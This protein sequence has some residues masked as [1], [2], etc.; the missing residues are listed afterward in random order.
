MKK[1]IFAF[2]FFALSYAQAQMTVT[3]L[4]GTPIVN[5]QIISF[6]S[7]IYNQ[8]SLG[9]K[10]NNT[11]S[12]TIYTRIR[13]ESITNT[14][15]IGM[16]LCVGPSCISDVVAGHSYPSNAVAIPANGTNGNSDHFY[17]SNPGN[18]VNYPMDY[19][20]KFYQVDTSTGNEIGNSITFTYRYSPNLVKESFDESLSNMGITLKSSLIQNQIDI[21]ALKETNVKI[22]D[23]NGKLIKS[24]N[25]ISGNNTI[26][27]S[28]L[29]TGVYILNCSNE[30]GKRGSIKIVKN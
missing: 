23:L 18:G 9:F 11:S 5:G 25:I 15:G 10:I 13:C 12:S 20:F 4:D 29:L 14:D 21:Q 1:I 30:E 22:Y 19:V 26:D 16:E 3:K 2:A 8:A 24:V 27:A 6:S 7:L 17:N 28:N